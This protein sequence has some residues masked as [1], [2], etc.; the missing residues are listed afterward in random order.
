MRFQLLHYLLNEESVCINQAKKREL[1]YK[2]VTK[3]SNSLL[4]EDEDIDMKLWNVN[5]TLYKI[6]D[7][8]KVSRNY[9]YSTQNHSSLH[10]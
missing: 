2:S 3:D 10:K 7:D 8:Q 9:C 6:R 1:A 4:Q 5:E